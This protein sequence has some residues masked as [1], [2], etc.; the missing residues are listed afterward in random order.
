M[1]SLLD[2][3]LRLS[4]TASASSASSLTEGSKCF[5]ST[6]KSRSWVWQAET[7]HVEEVLQESPKTLQ[8]KTVSEGMQGL[9]K[10]AYDNV[11]PGL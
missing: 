2:R 1:I 6:I 3:K 8:E 9:S 10:I 11:F 5:W 7:I 4:E